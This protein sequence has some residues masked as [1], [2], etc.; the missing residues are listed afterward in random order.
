MILAATTLHALQISGFFDQI[1]TIN[2]GI[3][4][5]ISGFVVACGVIWRVLRFIFKVDNAI[6]TLLLVAE[7]FESGHT[8]DEILQNQRA[9]R[10]VFEDRSKELDTADRLAVKLAED[11][12]TI[13]NTNAAIVNELSAQ[14]TSEILHIKEYMHENMHL[15][16]N[17]MQEDVYF[18]QMMTRQM[19]AMT[20]RLDGIMPYINRR[21]ESD[22]RDSS[23]T[24]D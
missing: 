17:Q 16:R 9:F 24:D 5:A 1:R 11:A 3:V 13:A 15:I 8:L 12:R 20:A 4:L 18:K 14:S 22:T 19:E 21:R 7:Q 10:Q 23:P 6:P 2:F